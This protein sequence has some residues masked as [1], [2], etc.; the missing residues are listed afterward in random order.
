MSATLATQKIEAFNASVRQPIDQ[1]A[2]ELRGLLGAKLVA[3]ITG[4]SATRVV[5]GWAEGNRHPSPSAEVKLR[6]A[7]RIARMIERSEGEAIVATWF[8]GMN[9][10]LGDRS[11]ARMLHENDF[12]ATAPKVLA[13]ASAFVGA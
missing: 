12:E 13:A 6:H 1:V 10:H 11:P 8:Q 5:R 9:P 7:F 4:V 2:A 3:Y